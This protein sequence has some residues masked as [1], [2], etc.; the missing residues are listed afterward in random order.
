MTKSQ[1]SL[2]ETSRSVGMFSYMGKSSYL[3]KPQS[4]ELVKMKKERS[5]SAKSWVCNCPEMFIY[6]KEYIFRCYFC[7]MERYDRKEPKEKTP[8]SDEVSQ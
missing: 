8:P 2:H 7:G 1:K 6:S 3:L 4:I 5:P